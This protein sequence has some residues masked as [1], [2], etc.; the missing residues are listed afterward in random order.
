MKWKG[1]RQSS[2]VT[3]ARGRRMSGGRGVGNLGAIINLVLRLLGPKGLI[4]LAVAGVIAWQAGLIDPAAL[5]GGG[6]GRMQEVSYEPSL[7]EQE[8]F[9]FVSVVLADTEDIWAQEFARV[10]RSYQPPELVIYR[11]R[12]P[13]ACGVG[14]ARMGPFYCPADRK[15]YI[16]LGFYDDLAGQFN[17]PGDFAQAYVIAHEVGHHVQNLLGISEQVA[18]RRGQPDYNQWSVRLELQADFL[19]GVWARHNQRYL[20][21]GDIDEAMRA[22]NRIGDDAIQQRTRGRVTPHAFTHGTSEQR[23]RWFDRGY[24][25]GRLEDG[26]TFGI[27]YPEL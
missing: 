17:A 7:E 5:M 21:R 18:R 3:D 6:G 1:R 23:M 19:A 2:N 12:H 16:D 10:G 26:D 4:V 25:S 15:I 22:A 24:A 11:D 13:T 20:D 27:P 9:G 14:D 8:L